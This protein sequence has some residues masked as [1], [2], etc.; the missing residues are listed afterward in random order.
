[1]A[2]VATRSVEFRMISVGQL[3]PTGHSHSRPTEAA[4]AGYA[5][6]VRRLGRVPKPIT[7]RRLDDGYVIVDGEHSWRAAS[8][9]GLAEV[10]CEIIEGDDVE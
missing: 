2:E 8:E 10:P 6:A 3:R 9:V 4:C 5:A 7:V 1:M